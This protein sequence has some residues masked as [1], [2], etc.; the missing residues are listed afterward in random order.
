MKVPIDV[1]TS[2]AVSDVDHVKVFA[3]PERVR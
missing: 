3:S 1:D 2:K